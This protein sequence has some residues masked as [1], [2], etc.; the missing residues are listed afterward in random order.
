MPN[1]CAVALYVR[2]TP[3][4]LE[5][6]K[7]R[8]ASAKD[9]LDFDKLYPM[10]KDTE[11][12]LAE[13]MGS[14]WMRAK[15]ANNVNFA[16]RTFA[17]RAGA[18]ER[19]WKISFWGTKWGARDARLAEDAGCLTYDFWTAWS[20]PVDWI[21][22]VAKDFRWLKFR[23]EYWEPGCDFAGEIEIEAGRVAHALEGSCDD[24]EFSRVEFPDGDSEEEVAHPE[25]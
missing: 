24:F 10:P 13:T 22:K 15:A 6:F 9:V 5:R 1:N 11:E 18:A 23:M 25:G 14:V 2:G 17:E 3:K 4:Q 20:P 19:D 8:A 12:Q 7:S 16:P 21:K